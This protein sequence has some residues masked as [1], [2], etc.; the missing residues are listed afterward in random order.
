MT[1]C[2]FGMTIA[3]PS[4]YIRPSYFVIR[5]SLGVLGVSLPD[6]GP[7]LDACGTGVY[8]LTEEDVTNNCRTG[9]RSRV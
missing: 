8:T 6:S 4:I 3:R 7:T 9:Y 2:D 1:I 5:V